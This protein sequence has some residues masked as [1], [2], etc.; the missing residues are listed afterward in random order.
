VAR[1]V[2]IFVVVVTV[3]VALL[4][5]SAWLF[6][7]RLIYFPATNPVPP[8]SSVIPGARDVTI[9]TT[10]GLELGA[11]IVSPAAPDRRMT[12]LVANGNAGDRAGRAA[13]GRALAGQGFTVLL[14][15]YRGYG[16]NEGSPSETGLALD[17]R[18]AYD[19]LVEEAAVPPSRLIYLGESLGAAVVTELATEHPPAGLVLRSPFV[20][21]ASVGQDHYPFLPVRLLLKDDFPVADL[22]VAVDVPVCVVYG[23]SDSVVDPDQSRT[24]AHAA[25]S[26]WDLIEVSGADHNDDQL[27]HGEALIQAVVDLADDIA[28]RR[29]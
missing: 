12:V 10:D 26:L 6:Q 28:E 17:V 14:F 5:T 9:H 16:G 21:L 2:V 20:D 13:L 1:A 8:G 27:V 4:V 15:D 25:P 22:I 7:R 19:Y 11:W 23:S 3:G 29:P 18:A 24:V